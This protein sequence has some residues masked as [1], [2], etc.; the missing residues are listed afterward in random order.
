MVLRRRRALFSYLL[1]RYNDDDRGTNLE[2]ILAPALIVASG[3]SLEYLFSTVEGGAGTKVPMNLVGNFG[4]QQGVS[5][6][7]LVGLPTQM[8][9]MH[10]P[11]RALY[12][13]DA[14]IARVEAVLGRREDLSNLVRN[15]WVRFFVRDPD[16]QQVFR[17]KDGEYVPVGLEGEAVAPAEAS[18]F[19]PFTEQDEYSRKLKSEEDL[20]TGAA[21]LIMLASCGLPLYASG[22]DA[23]TAAV[24]AGAATLGLASLGFSRR[25]LHGE[26][27]YGRLALLSAGMV[28]GFNLVA[29]APGLEDAA[30]GWSLLGFCST[31]LI[32]AF[33]DRPTARDNAAF[34][35]GAYQLSDA[36]LLVALAFGA[37]N[38]G[39]ANPIAAAGLL[40]AAAIKS[41]QFPLTGLFMRSMEGASSNSALG[42]AGLSAHAGV[43]LLAGTMDLWF[44]FEWA[45]A[46]LF[47][48]GLVT[49]VQSGCIANIRADR[50]GSLA[51]AT[52][53]TLGAIYVVLAA[54]YP[55]AALLLSF[56]HAAF[57]MNQ[58]LRSAN[59]I[60]DTHK[61]ESAL[62]HQEV[63]GSQVP[64]PLYKLGWAFNRVNTDLLK[65]PDLFQ[66]V[67]LRASLRLSRGAQYAAT[68]ALLLLVGA[69]HAPVVE[70]HL[71]ALLASEPAAA[72]AMLSLNVV[73]STALVRFLLGDVL[74]FSRFRH[75]SNAAPVDV[76]SSTNDPEAVDGLG[77]SAARLA[78]FAPVVVAA[79]AAALTAA[80]AVAAAGTGLY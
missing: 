21:A 13:I 20:Y 14:P 17:Q 80:A 19:V 37:T 57:R 45:R 61:L 33:N 25:Y 18:D 35:F 49:A 79:A 63:S 50:K 75:G 77:L 67:D 28:A 26:F 8:T 62:G 43:L 66:S 4:V 11:L 2:T 39:G 32:G 38:G 64:E 71:A 29:V 78:G 3:I 31:F 6:D 72:V 47:G 27:M 51:A 53:A 16:T 46:A 23:H 60:L 22:L 42:Y 68:A 58:V 30:L 15:N 5:G 73:G 44:G 70:E 69:I 41:S 40:L 76:G 1:L 65:L 48:C 74:D 34:A 7:L 54:G 52:S 36:A 9:E 55:D 12:L 56:G 10:S 24:T 59:T